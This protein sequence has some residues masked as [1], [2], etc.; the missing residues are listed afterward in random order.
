MAKS[1]LTKHMNTFDGNHDLGQKYRLSVRIGTGFTYTKY[2]TLMHFLNV[3]QCY[4][5]NPDLNSIQA[6]SHTHPHGQPSPALPTGL[7][8]FLLLAKAVA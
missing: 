6:R 1:T 7:R 3:T 2:N 8:V 5:H 4:W